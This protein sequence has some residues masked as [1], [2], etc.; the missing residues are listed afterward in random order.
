MTI[1]KGV[2]LN[3]VLVAL[4]LLVGCDA[5]G[6]RTLE[7]RAASGTVYFNLLVNTA[8]FQTGKGQAISM[9]LGKANGQI[10]LQAG[11]ATIK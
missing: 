9:Q 8:L 10:F 4:L 11:K 6:L 1:R 5:G 7:Q 2:S 3:V